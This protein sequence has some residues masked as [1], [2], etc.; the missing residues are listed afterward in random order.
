MD[1]VESLV[2]LGESRYGIDWSA[3]QASVIHRLR[4]TSALPLEVLEPRRFPTYWCVPLLVGDYVGAT[5]QAV[6]EDLER[7]VTG[8]L[9]RHFMFDA[10]RPFDVAG[11]DDGIRLAASAYDGCRM[12]GGGGTS[13]DAC[14]AAKCR[15]WTLLLTLGTWSILGEADDCSDYGAAMR[16]I[17]LVYSCLQIVDDWHDRADDAARGHWNMWV[18]E[19]AA[20]VLAIMEPLV[21]GARRSVEELRPRLLRRALVAQ[22]E[23]AVRE[24]ADL[25]NLYV[26]ERQPVSAFASPVS[27]SV[28]GTGLD[29]AVA[30]AVV[31]LDERL[32]DDVPGLWRDFNLPEVS[33][34]ST[35]CISAFVAAQLALAPE[36]RPVARAVAARLVAKART[37]GGWGYREDVPEDCDSTA[38]VLLAAT[39]TG[40]E[41]PPDLVRR[42]QQFIVNHQW[43]GGGFA[44]YGAQA[45]ASLT[46]GDQP[47]WFEPEV[48]VTSSALLALSA[49]GYA[50]EVRLQQACDFIAAH[51]DDDLWS[52]YWWRGFG[53]GTFL[54]V[55]A[56]SA[57]AGGRYDEQLSATQQAIEARCCGDGGLGEGESTPGVFATALALRALLLGPRLVANTAVDRAVKL[58]ARLQLPSGGWPPSAEMLAPGALDGQD[59][60]LRDNGVV[61]T[62]AV[63]AA[64]HAVRDHR[65]AV[66]AASSVV[67]G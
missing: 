45:R 6:V 54:A 37:S 10:Q 34:G 52:S 43:S 23:D 62:A 36:S 39:A 61:T 32:G 1:L 30:A 14:F 63:M 53:Y 35:E 11:E 17:V 55:W 47:G 3:I 50:D 38:W 59:V 27:R 64:L 31:F 66:A 16:A 13:F 8:C 57:V 42:S 28:L 24:L 67:S 49:T 20:R 7:F 58:L 18:N 21:S 56:L 9:I 60:S 65:R 44:T 12:D 33:A 5:R 48:S 25:V 19:S 26:S 22:L 15:P 29:A 51:R 40:V 41:L 4:P 46:P 2:D